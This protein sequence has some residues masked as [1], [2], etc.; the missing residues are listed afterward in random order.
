MDIDIKAWLFDIFNAIVEIESFF[1]DG[2]NDFSAYQ[3]DVKTGELLKG[4]LKS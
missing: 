2:S 4:I 3:K 1:T